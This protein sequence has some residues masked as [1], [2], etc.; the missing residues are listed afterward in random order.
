MENTQ[1]NLPAV[2]EA[3]LFVSTQEES[4]KN[5][6]AL[7]NIKEKEIEDALV[8]LAKECENRGVAILEHD[9]KIQMASN[10][11]YAAILSKYQQKNSR[12][13]LSD[14]AL[15]TLAIIAYR[16]PIS[17]YK[18]EEIRGVNSVFILRNLL[19]RG[20]VARKTEG[21]KV[22]YAITLD[23]LRYLGLTKITAL[24][25]YDQFQSRIKN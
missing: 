15:E 18:I 10:P 6:A 13:K 17:R 1:K 11:K 16:G 21:K 24:P 5:F 3:I 12:A 8:I 22:E 19:R 2:L 14:L 25:K 7:L 20:L 23:F 4:V 9:G